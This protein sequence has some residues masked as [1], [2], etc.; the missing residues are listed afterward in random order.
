MP[1]PPEE[2]H[3]ARCPTRTRT[4]GTA[5]RGRLSPSGAR[6][7]ATWPESA[8]A[9]PTSLPRR[10][11]PGGS[12]SPPVPLAHRGG[13]RAIGPSPTMSAGSSKCWTNAVSAAAWFT[14]TTAPGREET[15]TLPGRLGRGSKFLARPRPPG[16]VRRFD[17]N[18]SRRSL[19]TPRIGCR[20]DGGRRPATGIRDTTR[21]STTPSSYSATRS[22]SLKPPLL[23]GRLV[24]SCSS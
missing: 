12:T 4:L 18:Q 20:R 23:L 7:A 16:R 19:I 22:G 2:E 8:W 5:T 13:R 10:S 14:S 11:R 9:V 15:A 6:G 24:P 1:E 21:P 17:R 3:R